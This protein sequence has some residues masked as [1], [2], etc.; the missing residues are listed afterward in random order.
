[1]GWHLLL[2]AT[3]P[4]DLFDGFDKFCTG[5]IEQQRLKKYPPPAHP[6]FDLCEELKKKVEQRFLALRW[7]LVEFA[8]KRLPERKREINIRFFDDLLNDLYSALCGGERRQLSPPAS[9]AS[10]GRP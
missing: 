1:M 5:R 4:F 2:P 10:I 7:E 8:G 3:N 6:F 9:G